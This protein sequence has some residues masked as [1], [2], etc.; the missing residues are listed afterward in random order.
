MWPCDWLL[1][2]LGPIGREG[3][4]PTSDYVASCG[5]LLHDSMSKFSD[6]QSCDRLTRVPRPVGGGSIVVLLSDWEDEVAVLWP[7]HMI[8]RAIFQPCYHVTRVP[9]WWGVVTWC[10]RG[11]LSHV[12][13]ALFL[14]MRSC[15]N[16]LDVTIVELR[17]V[18]DASATEMFLFD[19]FLTTDK[20]VDFSKGPVTILRL[21]ADHPICRERIESRPMF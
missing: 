16:C 1:L 14:A 4:G 2:V 20:T 18:H 11:G 9:H 10:W 8:A 12:R 7:C 6:M 15:D 21:N 19:W 17:W 13:I 5:W 3:N